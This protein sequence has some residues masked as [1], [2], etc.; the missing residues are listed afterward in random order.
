MDKEIKVE[1]LKI[2]IGKKEIELNIEDA[3]KLKKALEDIFGKD[4]VHEYHDCWYY[5]PYRP[6]QPYWGT[7]WCGGTS[8]IAT[9]NT[10]ESNLTDISNSISNS[11]QLCMSIS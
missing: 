2:S 8:T 10:K 11:T 1:S 3:K 5:R 6:Y 4:V 7:I 9:L